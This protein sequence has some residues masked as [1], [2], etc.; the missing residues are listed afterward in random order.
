MMS[1]VR[2]L[3]TDIDAMVQGR[4]VMTQVIIAGIVR[5][6]LLVEMKMVVPRLGIAILFQVVLIVAPE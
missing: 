6:E 2:S 5:T 3:D 1:T 4:A